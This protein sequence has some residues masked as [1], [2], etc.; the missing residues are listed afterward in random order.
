MRWRCCAMPGRPNT[1]DNK[2]ANTTFAATLRRIADVMWGTPETF[3]TRLMKIVAEK[4][5]KRHPKALSRQH[6]ATPVPLL[7]VPYELVEMRAVA[8]RLHSFRCNKPTT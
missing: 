3:V 7:H 2:A 5:L 4:M 1:A 8:P 6:S